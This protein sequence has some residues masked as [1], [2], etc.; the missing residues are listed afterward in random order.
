MI[1][2]TNEWVMIFTV[3]CEQDESSEMILENSLTLEALGR[4]NDV[5]SCFQI[6]AEIVELLYTC[7]CKRTGAL[8]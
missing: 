6:I 8:V 5:R 7:A 2:S 4:R 3:K 1:V